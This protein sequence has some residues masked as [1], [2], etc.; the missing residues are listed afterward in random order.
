MGI[1]SDGTVTRMDAGTWGNSLEGALQE[2]TPSPTEED[3]ATQCIEGFKA[4]S[5]WHH[6]SICE[7]CASCGP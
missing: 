1:G 5:V 6:R 7:L 4:P 3:P 2:L